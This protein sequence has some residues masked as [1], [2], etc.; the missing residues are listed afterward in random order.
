LTP[1]QVVPSA[2]TASESCNSQK[3]II[4]PILV[5]LNHSGR[6][7]DNDLL[8][9]L[10]TILLDDLAYS[11][12]I[13]STLTLV[14]DGSLRGVPWAALPLPGSQNI[15][16]ERGPIQEL[17]PHLRAGQSRQKETLSGKD[18]QELSLL[19]IGCDRPSGDDL[20]SLRQAEHE[21]QNIHSSWKN[22]SKKLL[23]G[24]EAS[25]ENA[26]NEGLATAD[27]IHIA[28]HADVRHGSARRSTLRLTN[29]EASEAS[30]A[31]P[32]TMT[33][34]SQLNLRAQV[35]YLSSCRAGFSQQI[36]NKQTGD[37]ISSF[38]TSGANTVIAST[39]W[40]DDDAA[41]ALAESFYTNWHKYQNKAKALQV[42]RL[43]V[44]KTWS[45]PSYWAFIRLVSAD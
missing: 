8:A 36:G 22:D 44:R 24:N 21:A 39:K 7:A 17:L 26:L 41:R 35:V 11:W 42:A 23:I 15:V 25:W 10:A 13:G 4:S 5:D 32:V 33:A 18:P 40:M 37:F 31:T 45:H 28:S 29:N 20:A 3:K 34:V 12:S 30:Q 9:L 43:E 6:Q 2:T 1:P 27:V 16:L 19:A 14:L 38:L